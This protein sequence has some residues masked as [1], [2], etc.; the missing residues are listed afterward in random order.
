MD[1]WPRL[2]LSLSFLLGPGRQLFTSDKTLANSDQALAEEGVT[3][4]DWSQYDRE[5]PRNDEEE[6]GELRHYDSD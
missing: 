2:T 4:V 5:G 3:E 6:E 1:F